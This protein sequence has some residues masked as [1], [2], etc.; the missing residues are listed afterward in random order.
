MPFKKYD[1][2]YNHITETSTPEQIKQIFDRAYGKALNYLSY[3]P[4]SSK[5]IEEFLAKKEFDTEIIN[6]II[7]LLT[8]QKFL[9]DADFASW[10]T[11]GR[12][13]S[14]AKSKSIIKMEL[15]Q[16]GIAEDFIQEAFEE[17]LDDYETAKQYFEKRKKRF[18]GLPKE[19][20]FA[21]ASAFLQRRGF[22]WEVVKKVIKNED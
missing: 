19:E 6:N 12:Q 11:R 22:S 9:N 3:R 8:S 21:K 1:Y 14:Q 17:A 15:K 4:R 18:E 16:K 7:E 20:Y 5:E 2:S 13:N 10:W